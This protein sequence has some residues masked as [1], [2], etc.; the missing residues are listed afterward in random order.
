MSLDPDKK[1][2]ILDA[3][4]ERFAHYGFKK[5][6]IDEIAQAA[7]VGKGTVYLMAESK[8]DLF[9]QVVHR[10]L[11]RWTAMIGEHID[12]RVPADQLLMTCH[13]MGF[14]Y[15]RDKPLVRD[16]LLGN[17]EEVMPL[18]A[19][20]LEDLRQ[21]ARRRNR[22]ILEIGVR[23]GVFRTDLDL[24]AVAKL[25]QD[26]YVGALVVSYREHHDEAEQ[27]KMGILALDL[28][29]NGLRPR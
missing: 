27:L 4:T 9:Y 29:L 20:R 22:E 10:E 3:A 15:L 19:D 17:L 23:Q 11:Q 2:R 18:W 6:S 24:D 5:T 12:P 14:Q 7:G 25:F 8:E 26:L 21:V 13:A 28:L 16:L 1:R